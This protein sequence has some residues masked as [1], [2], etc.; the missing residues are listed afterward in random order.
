MR[1]NV[2]HGD[3]ELSPPQAQMLS[4]KAPPFYLPRARLSFRALL[5]NGVMHLSTLAFRCG[6]APGFPGESTE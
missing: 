2:L 1:G 4:S 3:K 5:G 6:S